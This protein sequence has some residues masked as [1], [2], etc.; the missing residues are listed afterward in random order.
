MNRKQ[1]KSCQSISNTILNKYMETDN[2]RLKLLLT[3][4]NN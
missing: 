3:I 2:T 1:K 4:L